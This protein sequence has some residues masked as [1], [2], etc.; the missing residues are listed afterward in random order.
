[1]DIKPASG[2]ADLKTTGLLQSNIQ[3]I[4]K[5]QAQNSETELQQDEVVLNRSVAVLISETAKVLEVRKE[6]LQALPTQIKDILQ[7]MI[8]QEMSFQNI[9]QEGIAEWLKKQKSLSDILIGSDMLEEHAVL[10]KEE[11]G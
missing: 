10:K 7:N 5:Q 3:Q 2:L 6:V 11:K 8:K 4:N 1:M 9:L